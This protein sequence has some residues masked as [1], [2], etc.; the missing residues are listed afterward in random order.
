MIRSLC[1]TLGVLMAAV[2]QAACPF[3]RASQC[4]ADGR[5]SALL[6]E[7][8]LTEGRLAEAAKA[9]TT[10]LKEHPTD[11]QAQYGLGVVRLLQAVEDL[12]HN[13]HR[14]GLKSTSPQ[15]PFVRL[16]TSSLI[17]STRVLMENGLP[18]SVSYCWQNSNRHFLF[19][20]KMS[21]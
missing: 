3:G 11:A 20:A 12:A 4:P 1:F 19:N 7:R 18:I 21:S 5:P 2:A 15:L 10:H 9:L 14:Y 8:F 6:V 17:V 13:L 16:S